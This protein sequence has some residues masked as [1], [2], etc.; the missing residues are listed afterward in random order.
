MTVEMEKGNNESIKGILLNFTQKT[1]IGAVQQIV[2]AR[3]LF[4]KL[5]WLLGLLAGLIMLIHNLRLNI[6]GFNKNQIN[7]FYSEGNKRPRFPDVTLCNLYQLNHMVGNN[8]LSWSVYKY[9]MYVRLK[10]HTEFLELLDLIDLENEIREKHLK[11]EDEYEDD[12]SMDGEFDGGQAGREDYWEE[13]NEAE[14][15]VDGASD[16]VIDDNHYDGQE[17]VGYDLHW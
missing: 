4:F 10:N 13:R 14:D 17:G 16:Y 9:L 11:G 1:S 5:F 15:Y 7:T 2:N 8:S 12:Y 3:S 6:L